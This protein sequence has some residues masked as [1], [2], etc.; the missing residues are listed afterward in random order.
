MPIGLAGLPRLF[1]LK[2]S[3]SGRENDED[4]LKD[5]LQYALCTPQSKLCVILRKAR[6]DFGTLNVGI[7]LLAATSNRAV[8]SRML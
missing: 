3:K 7:Q 2:R 8:N 5:L 6:S 4:D 1:G